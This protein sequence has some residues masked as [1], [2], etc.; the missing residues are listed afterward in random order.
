MK[1]SLKVPKNIP[2]L[3]EI[4]NDPNVMDSNVVYYESNSEP[5]H[6]TY[7]LF[8]TLKKEVNFGILFL[9]SP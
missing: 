6:F 7:S 9:V 4:W 1:N 3:K 2:I 8:L 5:I